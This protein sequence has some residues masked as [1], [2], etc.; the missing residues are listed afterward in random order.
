V[1]GD[2]I[3]LAIEDPRAVDVVSMLEEADAWY[4]SIYPPEQ[5][6]LLDVETLRR[7]EIRFF[8]A[9]DGGR[10]LGCGA[11]RI[12]AEGW[13]EIKRMYV[14]SEARGLGIA[15]RLLQRLEREAV[16]AGVSIL[17]LETGIRQ[18]EAVRLYECA[19]WRRRGV[20]GDYPD[21]PTS[22]FFEKV[23]SRDV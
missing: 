19:G 10:L 20:F 2:D 14:R 22:V 23:V 7:P 12:D 21:V 1:T 5:N 9:R 4:A 11:L 17:R 3:R 13:G 16:E 15:R 6:H 18:P 8:T